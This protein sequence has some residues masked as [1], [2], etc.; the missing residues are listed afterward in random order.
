[1]MQTFFTSPRSAKD[2]WN[3]WLR[4]LSRECTS[5]RAVTRSKNK[6][7]EL[8]M[9]MILSLNVRT[10]LLPL[11]LLRERERE[12]VI[13][14]GGIQDREIL[15]FFNFSGTLSLLTHHS[16]TIS[17]YLAKIILWKTLTTAKGEEQVKE[18][19]SSTIR[20]STVLLISMLCKLTMINCK[21]IIEDARN[22]DT[23]Y[24]KYPV[25]LT[26]SLWLVCI[27]LLLCSRSIV[28]KLN[29]LKQSSLMG[30][31]T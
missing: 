17:N 31:V 8:M 4:Y 7:Y 26:S 29:D 5:R 6:T 11:L 27:Q 1:M 21:L 18:R 12:R 3:G 2:D 9:A 22:S 16:S 15:Q 24:W 14:I 30:R 23:W 20:R 13:L 28:I 25:W 10:G 19:S